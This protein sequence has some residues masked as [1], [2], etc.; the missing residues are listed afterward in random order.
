MGTEC[1]GFDVSSGPVTTEETT[2]K[3]EWD[4]SGMVESL[5]YVSQDVWDGEDIL[6]RSKVTVQGPIPLKR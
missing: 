3:K 5:P 4:N 6:G 2:L 1:V